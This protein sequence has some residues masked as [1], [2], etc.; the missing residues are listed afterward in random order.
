M[1]K[2]SANT[3]AYGTQEFAMTA[4]KALLDSAAGFTPEPVVAHDMIPSDAVHH[5]RRAEFK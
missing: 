2:T 4:L 5:V 3:P 1:K